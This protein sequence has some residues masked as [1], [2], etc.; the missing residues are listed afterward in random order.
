MHRV[1]MQKVAERAGVS[2]TTVSYVLNN[3]PNSA[4]PAHTCERVR[5][6]AAEMGYR[7]NAIARSLVHGRTHTLGFV[8]A[9][10]KSPFFA[11]LTDALYRAARQRGYELLIA[12]D[13]TS[14]EEEAE[15]IERFMERRVDGI[16]VWCGR[17]RREYPDGQSLDAQRTPYVVIGMGLAD[18]VTSYINVDRPAGLELAVEHLVRMGHTRIGYLGDDATP[19]PS[20]G[21]ASKYAGFLAA[22]RRRGLEPAISLHTPMPSRRVS[23]VRTVGYEAGVRLAELPQRPQAVIC[24]GDLLAIGAMMALGDRGIRVPEEMAV[25]GFDGLTDGAFTR[26]RL[27]TIAHP[28]AEL[29]EQG[30]AAVLRLMDGPDAAPQRATLTPKLIVR[31]SCGASPRATEA[32]G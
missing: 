31:E 8:L 12:L 5:R 22:L 17:A 19:S 6:V 29:A 23:E 24:G 14:F 30:I 7:P 1:T 27:T 32:G 16:L 15:H 21:R 20:L 2:Q 4:I 11:E 25:V 26:P 18:E 28:V 9:T 13:D 10:L 3:R